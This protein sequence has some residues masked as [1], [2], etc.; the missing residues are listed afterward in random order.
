VQCEAELI[1]PITC[2]CLRYI[3]E[4]RHS[5]KLREN[6]NFLRHGEHSAVIAKIIWLMV[7]T[8]IIP[9][10]LYHTKRTNWVVAWYYIGW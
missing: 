9:Y 6:I 3:P 8:E 10:L 1:S 7:F 4:D 5:S 2:D